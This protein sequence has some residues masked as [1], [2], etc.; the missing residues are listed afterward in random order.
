M[1][2]DMRPTERAP[3][4]AL[5]PVRLGA[6]LAGVREPFDPPP[7][8]LLAAFLTRP[9]IWRALLFLVLMKSPFLEFYE[10]CF[11]EVFPM[12]IPREV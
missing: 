1:R 10:F 5:V 2:V 9:M 12:K 3:A 4:R 11:Q 6:R 8:R 7:A